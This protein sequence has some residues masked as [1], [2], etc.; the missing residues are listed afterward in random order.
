MNRLAVLM[1]PAIAGAL[2]ACGSA[3]PRAGSNVHIGGVVHARAEAKRRSNDAAPE[4]ESMWF[5]SL[6]IARG[7]EW[8]GTIDTSTNVASLEIRSNLFSIAA[9]RSDFGHF[10]FRTEVFDVP[11]IFVRAYRLRIIARNTAGDEAE[12]DVPFRIR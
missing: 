8:R 5:D 9:K 2:V 4:I 3:A 11:S 6:D 10:A 1:L 12:T 7:G